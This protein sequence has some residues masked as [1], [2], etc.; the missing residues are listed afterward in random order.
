[1]R[2]AP[3]TSE[4]GFSMVALVAGVTISMM[5]MGAAVPAWRYVIRDDREE[6]LIFRGT[7]IADAI[8]RFQ[9]KNGGALPTNLE[10][11]VKGRYLRK[12]Y[13]DPMS[14]D[15]KWRLVRQGEG[16]TPPGLPMPGGSPNPSASA[17]PGTPFG[18]STVGLSSG[19]G[20][21][22]SGSGATGA[23][24]Q[25]Y[26]P[27][28]GVASTNTEESLRVFNGRTKY[29]EWLFVIGQPRIVGKTPLRGA[30]PPG[31]RL[32]GQ[33]G[34]APVPQPPVLPPRQ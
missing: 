32:P 12:E 21:R 23:G 27:F 1:M 22:P 31:G 28:V 2:P 25:V 26:G 4:R 29:N 16:L 30:A 14:K 24:G 8:A 5:V 17:S 13:K 7:Q 9:K 33:P 10:M 18:P 3:R 6:E 20:I 15:G 11:L 34:G 19:A